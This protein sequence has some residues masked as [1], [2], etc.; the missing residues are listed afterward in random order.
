MSQRKLIRRAPHST[1]TKNLEKKK[2]FSLSI[3]LGG[4][5]VWGGLSD[6]GGGWG[7]DKGGASTVSK[8]EKRRKLLFVG[9]G[10]ASQLQ[11]LEKGKWKGG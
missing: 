2:G 8:G 1:T 11:L 4:S 9:G 7:T 5:E 10:S 6:K 3:L